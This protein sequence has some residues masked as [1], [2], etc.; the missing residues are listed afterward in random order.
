MK[1]LEG[2]VGTML[3]VA[4]ELRLRASQA[5]YL[6]GLVKRVCIV[7]LHHACFWTRLPDC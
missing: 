3:F 4:K 6:E 7:V 1:M 2:P 5:A